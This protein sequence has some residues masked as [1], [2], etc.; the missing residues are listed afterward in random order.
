MDPS[1]LTRASTA[2]R[3]NLALNT[4]LEPIVILDRREKTASGILVRLT[5]CVSRSQSLE[6][7]LLQLRFVLLHRMRNFLF[8]LQVHP[9]E[10]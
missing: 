6:L 3:G 1:E 10:I 9:E 7:T 8:F 5:F 4:E 2:R